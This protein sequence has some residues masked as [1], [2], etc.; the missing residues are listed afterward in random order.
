MKLLLKIFLLLLLPAFV[1]AQHPHKQLD[2]LRMVLGNAA[3]DTIRMEIY[4]ELGWYYQ[5]I[6]HD[7]I[8][9][10]AQQALQLAKQLNQKLDE[11]DALNA[12]AS[13]FMA[14]ENY[15]QALE[16]LTQALQIAQDPASEKNTRHLPWGQPVDY[17]LSIL[18]LSH[19]YM[20]SLYEETGNIKEQISILQ[21]TI[22]FADSIHNTRLEAWASGDLGGA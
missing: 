20:G 4:S 10:Y 19:L 17:R 22:K 2:S 1:R 13:A 6:N 18:G 8:L 11:A 3:N 5:E 14:L 7:S 12:R 21:E 16:S 9:F 15:P